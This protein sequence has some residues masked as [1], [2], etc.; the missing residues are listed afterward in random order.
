[1]CRSGCA[2]FGPTPLGLDLLV[3]DFYRDGLPD[4]GRA[5]GQDSLGARCKTKE[6]K[7][8][9]AVANNAAIDL[10]EA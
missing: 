3:A 1:M 5:E 6:S 8:G 4:L 2:F 7:I 9:I 10:P